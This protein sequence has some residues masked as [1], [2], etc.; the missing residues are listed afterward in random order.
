MGQVLSSVSC[1]ANGWWER[2]PNSGNTNNFCN[3]NSSG[4]ANNN[5]A[6]N[7][8]GVSFGFCNFV[9]VSRSNPVG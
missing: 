5:N 8:N 7:S 6:N 1:S 4:N 9:W 3:V 2:S